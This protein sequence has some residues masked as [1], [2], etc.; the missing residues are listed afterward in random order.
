MFS[1]EN[2]R[3]RP[4]N[5]PAIAGMRQEVAI[6]GLAPLKVPNNNILFFYSPTCKHCNKILPQLE[7]YVKLHPDVNLIKINATNE[8]NANWLETLLK[9]HLV[10]PTAIINNAFLIKN[11]SNFM[12]RLTY[13]MQIA[14]TMPESKEVTQKRLLTATN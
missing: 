5:A 1:G 4:E 3:R 11:D 12:Q 2:K 8:E 14:S 13:L 7:E 10:V 9:G 6:L